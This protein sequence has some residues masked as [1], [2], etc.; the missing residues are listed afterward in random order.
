VINQNNAKNF[1]CDQTDDTTREVDHDSSNIVDIKDMSEL[2]QLEDK[3]EGLYHR[4][5]GYLV[6]QRIEGKRIF[7]RRPGE[8]KEKMFYWQGCTGK[9]ELKADE[10]S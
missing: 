2:Q 7:G 4:H 5:H 6:F 8:T 3:I 1:P 9:V 10:E